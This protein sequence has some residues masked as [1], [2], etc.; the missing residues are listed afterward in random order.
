MYI[1][2]S[3]SQGQLGCLSFSSPLVLLFRE[4]SIHPVHVHSTNIDVDS[5]LV[6]KDEKKRQ[7]SP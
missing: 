4:D 6:L 7:E 3:C 2:Q 1:P 5:M